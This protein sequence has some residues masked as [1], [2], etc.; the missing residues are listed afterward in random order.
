MSTFARKV[1]EFYKNRMDVWGGRYI[2]DGRNPTEESILLTSNDYLSLSNHQEILRVQS[3]ALLSQGN[4][5]MMSSVFLGN[6]SQQRKL[7][8][9]FAKFLQTENAVI[10]Q[11]GWCA[12]VGLLQCIADERTFV[13]I[14]SIAHMS[15]WEGVKSAG[16]LPKLFRHND[17][18]HLERQIKKNGPGVIAVDSIYSTDG[19]VCP[20]ID[21]VSVATQYGCVILV[22]ESHSLGTHGPR[23]AG[24]VVSLGLN[25][26]VHFRTAS[27][28]KAFCGRAG[29]ITCSSA[30]HLYFRTTSFP[31]VF[32]SA[33]FPHELA[34]LKKT[35]EIIQ[36]SDD[37]RA[38]LHHNA[39]YLRKGLDS[40]GYNVGPDVTQIIALEAGSEGDT[41]KLRDLLEE[42][43]IFGAVFAAPATAQNRSLV[44]FSVHSALSSSH[45]ERILEVCRD[46]REGVQVDTWPSTARKQ[47]RNRSSENQTSS[48]S[49]SP[50]CD[51]A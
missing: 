32:S 21:V 25:D 34:A 31:A 47:R 27:L 11:S 1:A 20:L 33:L 23:G 36:T 28:S 37:R 30:F 9:D 18:S 49:I 5:L 24:L 35:L 3:E 8:R 22:D 7:E 38:A 12:N 15:L 50:G 44:R 29:I 41:M 46:I 4:G 39:G 51:S 43:N 26:K 10:C 2:L 42:R 14:D 16:A 19:S 6:E 40:L 13:Y 45:L 17:I 48:S